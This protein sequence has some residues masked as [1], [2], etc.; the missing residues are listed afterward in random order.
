MELKVCHFGLWLNL[1]IRW[2]HND[3]EYKCFYPL[4]AQV[5]LSLLQTKYLITIKKFRRFD[6]RKTRL[7]FNWTTDWPVHPIVSQDRQKKQCQTKR[8]WIKIE[9]AWM[10]I[11][12]NSINLPSLA[13]LISYVWM[14]IDCQRYEFILE[15][16]FSYLC[17]HISQSR[18]QH[19]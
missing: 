6:C 4:H 18:I 13:V 16:T 14:Q 1:F 5:Q 2:Q 3:Y 10:T 11:H 9:G 15:L 12:T 7:V 8:I 19:P 17:H